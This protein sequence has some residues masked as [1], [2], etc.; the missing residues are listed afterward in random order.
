VALWRGRIEE[1]RGYVDADLPKNAFSLFLSAAILPILG[2]VTAD[3]D[4]HEIAR[5]WVDRPAPPIQRGA[6][7]F[8]DLARALTTGEG[9]DPS[10]ARSW[11]DELLNAAPTSVV[12]F[13]T[14]LAAAYLSLNDVA[15]A[16]AIGDSLRVG[17][18]ALGDPPLHLATCAQISA[19]TALARHEFEGAANAARELLAIA[20][21]HGVVLLQIDGLE[22]LALSGTLPGEATAPLLAAAQRARSEIGYLG[23]WPNLAKDVDA[24]IEHAAREQAPAFELLT[25]HRRPATSDRRLLATV[26]CWCHL[27]SAEEHAV[28]FV[29][30]TGGERP[31][32]PRV[33]PVDDV[34]AVLACREVDRHR[35]IDEVTLVAVVDV[36]DPRP[37]AAAGPANVEAHV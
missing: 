10:D 23:R 33:G 37:G 11:F 21:R 26:G 20:S 22:L 27:R 12:Q 3:V 36:M 6:A 25:R 1:A 30:D 9:F 28:A 18:A 31:L 32:A 5:H 34:A 35:T 8:A 29:T 13:A 16:H 19:M 17:A 4:T 15:N 7:A 24:A 2:F 14:P